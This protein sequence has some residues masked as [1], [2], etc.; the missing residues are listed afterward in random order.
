MFNDTIRY[1][2]ALGQSFSDEE[3]LEVLEAVGLVD[4][5]DHILDVMI[6]DNGTNISGG[7]RVRLEIARFLLRK[8]ISYWQ[9]RLQLLLMLLIVKSQRYSVKLTYFSIRNCPL[10]G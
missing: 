1:N 10:C 4:E 6:V 9:M 5:M 2:L 7:Q 3:L 8:K